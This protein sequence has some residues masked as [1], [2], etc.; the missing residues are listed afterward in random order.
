[1]SIQ[2]QHNKVDYLFVGAGAST[3]L[4]LMSMERHGLLKD[5]K[6]LIIDP[7]K[8]KNNDKTFCFWSEQNEDLTLKCQH[9]ISHK[10]DQV[11]VN[12]N[13]PE[14]LFPKNYF[15]ISGIDVY[16]ELRRI[17]IQHNLQRVDS[18]VIELVSIEKA[19]KVITT[20][21]IWESTIVFD[22][23]PPQYF[24]LKKEDAHLLQSFIGYVITTEEPI[25]KINCVDLMDFNVEQLDSTQFMYVLP[26]GNG[27]T[28]VELTRFGLASIT[29]KEADPILH[30]YII[31]RFGNYK[32]HDTEI[33]CI[34]MSTANISTESIPGV[35][36]IGGRAG[37][38]KPSTGYAFK[39]M[40]TH[41]EKLANNLKKGIES[42]R[43]N[44]ISRFRFYDRLLLLILSTQPSQGKRIFQSLF[45]KNQT[46][47]VLQFLDE[48]TTLIQDIR[49]FST[50]PIKPFLKAVLWVVSSQIQRLITP[51]ILLLLSLSLLFVYKI[52]PNIF[53]GI[54][55]VIF[56]AG[57]FL[58]G[59]PHGAVDHL[60]ESNN[61]K[62]N[63]KLGFIINY[64]SFTF[65]NFVLWLFFP[66]IALLFF[67]GYSAWHFGQ[68]DLR[69]WQPQNTNALKNAS[70]GY[71][72]LGIILCGHL[73]ETNSILGNMNVLKIPLNNIQGKEIS[74]FLA[75]A[76]F[77]WSIFEKSRKMLLT[78]LMLLVSTELP[79]LTSFGLYF[80]GQHSLSGW[81]HLKKAMK[82]NNASLYLKAL[83]FTI[84]ALILF[85]TFILLLKNDYLSYFNEN[86]TTIFFV[87]ISCISFPHVI[88]MNKFYKNNFK[89][90]LQEYF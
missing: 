8:K 77:G 69:E 62:V 2:I 26:L 45:K 39:N 78:I 1:M 6:V 31:Q 23:R 33:G 16:N 86:M 89:F 29:Q 34:P 41:S 48:K 43:I 51:F 44:N 52:T 73:A 17:I 55:I 79:L 60:L 5:K 9:L 32:I 61:L 13:T 80:I 4:L 21:D 75:I 35:I 76:G 12:R 84:G 66:T 27:N 64:L 88:F 87:F 74:I 90:I 49:I 42:A 15:H 38:I 18:K 67:I 14:Y 56:I 68:T 24:P 83:P 20:T 58:I 71:L 3:T 22:S 57:M 28:L 50:L 30:S 25:S 54:E 40:F 37:A 59:I 19:V 11:S 36:S 81:S 72:I 53:H 65:F 85:V 46:K 10:W 63:I 47:D 82:V 7:D 70:W